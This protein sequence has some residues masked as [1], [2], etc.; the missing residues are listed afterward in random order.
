MQRA[1]SPFCCHARVTTP[2]YVI[3]RVCVIHACVYAMGQCALCRYAFLQ[4]VFN[5]ID[6][7]KN[8]VL[9][10][11]DFGDLTVTSRGAATARRR[12]ELLQSNFDL[13]GNRQVIA[14]WCNRQV[15]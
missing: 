8:G 6:T 2:Q 9:T 5:A 10:A 12:W 13:T 11:R 4:K 1:H 3:E 15:V 14:R 7:D